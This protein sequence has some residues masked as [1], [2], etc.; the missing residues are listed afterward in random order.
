MSNPRL[1][2]FRCPLAFSG[3]SIL[4]EPDAAHGIDTHN[5]TT[6][7]CIVDSKSDLVVSGHA[8]FGSGLRILCAEMSICTINVRLMNG[9]N[10][11]SRFNQGRSKAVSVHRGQGVARKGR[12]RVQTYA[13]Q[14][15]GDG[16]FA[17]NLRIHVEHPSKG[18]RLST[19]PL[20]CVCF[21]VVLEPG[22]GVLHLIGYL[23]P[24]LAA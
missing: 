3:G 23:R 4:P 2:C 9:R 1:S 14:P 16:I 22:Q 12:I 24:L 6:T 17:E 8:L 10:R 15:S 7:V 21:R 19:V 5:T 13:A 11:M 20:L 18:A